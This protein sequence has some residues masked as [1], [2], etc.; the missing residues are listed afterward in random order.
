MH[1]YRYDRHISLHRLLTAFLLV[2][3]GASSQAA[4]DWRDQP[5]AYR[6]IDQD[7]RG[8]LTELGRNLGMP[9]IVSKQVEGK[10]RGDISAE[11]AGDFLARVAGANGLLWY[12]DGT[13]L[14]IDRE[15]DIGTRSYDVRALDK[16]ALERSLA[17][18]SDN[19]S[20]LI[21]NRLEGDGLLTV[22]GPPGYLERVQQHVD[23][24]R[25]TQRAAKRG[26]TESGVR[27]FRGGAQTEVV[28]ERS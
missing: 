13:A 25:P 22:F 6:V 3:A 18:L 11:T 12:Q 27:V 16:A 19:V 14:V 1:L 20:P 28:S 10:V 17:T 2:V 23:A 26:G 8:V 21:T 4:E 15:A 9:V 7:V 24:L 5:Y